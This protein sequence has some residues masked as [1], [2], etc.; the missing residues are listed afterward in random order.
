M[1]NGVS[2][3]KK[4]SDLYARI[5]DYKKF[6]ASIKSTEHSRFKLLHEKLSTIQ[7]D[8]R[9]SR[10]IASEIIKDYEKSILSARTDLRLLGFDPDK[11]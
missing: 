9:L 4:A 1:S 3:A 6:I 2:V 11:K 10:M 5:E 7:L 8:S